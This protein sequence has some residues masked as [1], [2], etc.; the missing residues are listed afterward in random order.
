MTRFHD[1]DYAAAG[2]FVDGEMAEPERTRFE[3]RLAADPAL[4]QHVEELLRMDE[5]A[6][7]AARRAVEARPKSRLRLLPAIALAAASVAVVLGVRAWFDARLEPARAQ[8]A[9]VPSYESAA[10]W[11]A[12]D[13]SLTGRRPPGL[14]ELRGANETPNVDAR[15]F[16][17]AVLRLESSRFGVATPAVTTAAFFALPVRATE[18]VDVLVFGFPKGGTP[19]RYWPESA[20]PSA[21]RVEAGDHVL[22]GPSFTLVSDPRG[23][24][25]EYR[26]GFLVPIG[27]ERVTVIV[28]SRAANGSALEARSLAPASDAATASSELDAA[29]FAT[30]TFTVVEP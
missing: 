22:P 12:S 4:A 20:D 8:V 18:P 3:L 9:L 6:R 24:R 26:R 25:V 5:V 10:E 16:L 23:D 1:E 2:A 29:G 13:P 27:A 21:A 30:E 17:D 14:D 7:S 28:A 15:T 11:I 19:V